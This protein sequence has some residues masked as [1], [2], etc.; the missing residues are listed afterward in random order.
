M[1]SHQDT[2]EDTERV[3]PHAAARIH[4]R[5]SAVAALFVVAAV[6]TAAAVTVA[7]LDASAG[8]PYHAP[9]YWSVY[10]HHILKEYAGVPDNY[11]PESE[12]LANIDWVETN[13]KPYGYGMVCVDGWGDVTQVNEHGYRTSHSAHWTH[14][15]AWWSA[16]LQSRGMTLGMYDNPLW[17]H[18]AAIDDSATIVGTGLLV[19]SLVDPEED[20]LWFTWVQVDR[21]GAEEY[22]KGCVQHYA[23]MGVPYL[24]VD[25]LS[26][27]ESGYDRNLG[28]VG[29]NRPTEH[30]ETALRWM[31]EACDANGMYLSL[32]MPNMFNEAELE[33][34]YGHMTRIN[35]DCGEGTWWRF[36]DVSRGIRYPTWSQY[37]SAFDGC[38]YWSH[39]AGRD[40]IDLDGDFIRLNTFAS[41]SEK[42][43]VVSLHLVA[44][45]PVTVSDQYSTIGDDVWLYQNDELLALNADGFTGQPLSNDP[46]SAASQVWT[47]QMADGDW[48]VALFNRE[49]VPHTRSID[50]ADL[51]FAGPVKVRDLWQHADLGMMTYVSSVVPPHGCLILEVTGEMCACAE[52]SIAF[53][54]I[55]DVVFDGSGIAPIATATSGL[56]VEFEV[57]LGPAFVEDGVIELTGEAGTVHVLAK[58]PGD[59]TWCAAFPE[60]Q[61]FE[62]SGGHQDAM[63]VAGTFTG[64]APDI[65]MTLVDHI[66]VAQDVPITAGYHELK[67]ANTPD[68]SGDDWGNATGLAGIAQ[69][70]TG[71]YPNISF[72]MP[73]T[74]LY[75]IR[76]DDINLAYT[77]GDGGTGVGD[78]EM[79]GRAALRQNSPNPFNPVTTIRYELP[80]PARV[81]LDI[82]DA[83][84]RLVR[85]LAAGEERAAGEHTALW[86]G[87]DE[88]G[89]RV[90]SGVYFYR[91]LSSGEVLT[92]KMLL[93]E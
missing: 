89:Q 48:V 91:L 57:A 28:T 44:G 15:Y 50:L 25:F 38:A 58:Q 49:T 39:I 79:P 34:R 53:D 23:D 32:V 65:P 31:R 6:L 67:F 29:P 41:D 61:S 1:S 78:G 64:W 75:E 36:S 7:P 24:R 77:I 66:W 90:G 82:H 68:W 26:W 55:D 11:I 93:V 3:A 4:R 80:I 76:F 88:A 5:T 30:Y 10:E 73:E 85:R 62:V 43:S 20:A 13:L 33:R 84:G 18:Q 2:Q 47:G 74:G 81:T 17:I 70:A 86:D 21:P 9:L 52:Q 22:V 42:R 12:L 71:G 40:S 60:L 87:H 56:P 69:L 72:T 35:A 45:G 37:E 59:E 27:F 54:P 92:R 46:T 51:G 19:E 8:N 63:Y 14:D 16:E 83:S